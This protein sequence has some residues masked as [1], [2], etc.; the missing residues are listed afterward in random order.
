VARFV[1]KPAAPRAA[2]LVAGG[3]LWNSGIFAWPVGVFLDELAA[4]CPAVAGPLARAGEHAPT[5]FNAITEPVAVDVGV[6]ERS[7]KVYVLPG[8]FGWSDVGTWAALRAVRAADADGNV[9]HGAVHLREAHG[10]VVH[11]ESADVVLYGVSDLV[12]VARPGVVLVTTEARA[13]NLKPLLESL[14]PEVR[15]RR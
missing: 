11:A 12:V 2:E 8:S 14:P 6:L 13:R 10:N 9:S 3:A 7:D 5:F 1:E 15:E 4:H